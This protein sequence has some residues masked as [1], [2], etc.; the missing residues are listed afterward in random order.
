MCMFI[1]E[2]YIVLVSTDFS[3]H[4]AFMLHSMT[5]TSN[6][7]NRE[8]KAGKFQEHSGHIER[9]VFACSVSLKESGY[10]DYRGELSLST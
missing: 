3:S 1:T 8:W 2:S 9:F 7:R 4:E 10:L 6:Y 5:P